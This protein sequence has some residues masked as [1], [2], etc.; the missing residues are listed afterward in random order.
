MSLFSTALD[1]TG[2]SPFPNTHPATVRVA[3]PRCG[4]GMPS[5]GWGGKTKNQDKNKSQFSAS[6]PCNR[7]KEEMDG[8]GQA[9]VD[10]PPAATC[11]SSSGLHWEMDGWAGEVSSPKRAGVSLQVGL[12]PLLHLFTH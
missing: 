2:M 6:F 9:G 8:D 1:P 4:T 7:P 3:R 10:K 12:Q 5:A 11:G